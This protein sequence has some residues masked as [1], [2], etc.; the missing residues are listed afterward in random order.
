M[1][2]P[3]NI[4]IYVSV[5]LAVFIITSYTIYYTRR[6]KRRIE[7]AKR[8]CREIGIPPTEEKLKRMTY[9]ESPD[10]KYVEEDFVSK[11]NRTSA[12]NVLKVSILI[13]F[14]TFLGLGDL[15]IVIKIIVSAVSIPFA[16]MYDPYPYNGA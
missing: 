1:Q 4:V 15:P 3:E 5:F 6:K 7:W 14:L 10:G 13:I 8:F 2:N 11:I 16:L 9:E 12:S